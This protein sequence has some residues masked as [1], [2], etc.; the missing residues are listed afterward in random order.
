MKLKFMNVKFKKKIV[1][2]LVFTSKKEREEKI[3]LNYETSNSLLWN[4]TL[5]S[6]PLHNC[7]SH[8]PPINNNNVTDARHVKRLAKKLWYWRNGSD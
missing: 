3:F 5:W 2:N 1:Q 6:L 7:H 8:V 4:I